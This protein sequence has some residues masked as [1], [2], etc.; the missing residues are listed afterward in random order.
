MKKELAP[1]K[2][3]ERKIMFPTETAVNVP[4]RENENKPQMDPDKD[5]TANARE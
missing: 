1:A 3:R 5:L 2:M 4:E